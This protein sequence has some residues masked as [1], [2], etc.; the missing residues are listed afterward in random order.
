LKAIKKQFRLNVKLVSMLW[1]KIGDKV[2]LENN[3]I[4]SA[5][6]CRFL[7]L[8]KY[9]ALQICDDED[10]ET[11]IESF[12]QQEQMSVLELYIE[13]D[14]AGGS[15]FHSANSVT[16]CGNNLSNNKSEPPRNVSNLHDD[17][18]DDDDYLVSNSYVEESL[19][20]DDSVDGISDTDDK[21]TDMIQLVIIVHPTEGIFY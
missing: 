1:K 4:I 10:V 6:S 11:M 13:K 16:S 17:E 15:M 14:V 19:D 8:G 7:V 3:E 12:Q 21:V 2:K 9:V 20:E 18:D 5:I